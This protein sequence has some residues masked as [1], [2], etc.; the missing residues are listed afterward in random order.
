MVTSRHREERLGRSMQRVSQRSEQLTTT[1]DGL[2]TM[3]APGVQT[4]GTGVQRLERRPAFPSLGFDPNLPVIYWRVVGT[5][6][7][8]RGD[9][10][11]E[12]ATFEGRQDPMV[13]WK[14]S[15]FGP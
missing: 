7:E 6:F 3:G 10:A 5:W 13:P 1:T 2:R 8:T 9:H 15:Q 11:P 14:E 4:E 12:G